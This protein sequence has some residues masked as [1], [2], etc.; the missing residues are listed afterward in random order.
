M[1]R[2]RWWVRIFSDNIAL[3]YFYFIFILYLAWYVYVCASACY[4]MLC[5][6]HHTNTNKSL[7]DIK[8]L[9]GTSWPEF[10][11]LWLTR[12]F[13]LCFFVSFI[14]TFLLLFN[15]LSPQMEWL[16]SKIPRLY[17]SNDI[18]THKYAYMDIRLPTVMKQYKRKGTKSDLRS[19][20]H[21]HMYVYKGIR[22]YSVIQSHKLDSIKTIARREARPQ[23][24][25]I[26]SFGFYFVF[27]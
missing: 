3:C 20:A 6:V 24:L 14:L 21:T 22:A 10:L 15:L 12:S 9:R 18:H 16:N 26:Y 17:H 19:R 25:Y 5:C 11:W 7:K 1:R 23:Q 13:R 4:N 2:W 8:A 27:I